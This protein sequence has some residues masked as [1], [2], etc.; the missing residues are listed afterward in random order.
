MHSSFNFLLFFPP[1]FSVCL[2]PQLWWTPM[3]W[4]DTPLSQQNLDITCSM[5]KVFSETLAVC[6]LY[7]RCMWLHIQEI[8]RGYITNMCRKQK[9][10]NLIIMGKLLGKKK[11]GDIKKNIWMDW[12]SNMQL[13]GQLIDL[14]CIN[15]R[16]IIVKIYWHF[17]KWVMKCFKYVILIDQKCVSKLHMSNVIEIMWYVQQYM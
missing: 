5:T 8:G 11:N 17:T 13:E 1:C 4:R 3:W 14:D 12:P 2:E 6:L 10:E 15:W 16:C 7:S 9:L